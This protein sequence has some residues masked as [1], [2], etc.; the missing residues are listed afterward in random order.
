MSEFTVD[1]HTEIPR[2]QFKVLHET[3]RK[4]KTTVGALVAELVRRGLTEPTAPA[5]KRPGR[6]GPTKAQ[7]TTVRE[8]HALNRSDR[9]IAEAMGIGESTAR[10]W[11]GQL[12]LPRVRR[13]L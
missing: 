10:R 1:V 3:A 8:M 7:L 9:D 2:G 11:R 12:K 13:S 5:L 6:P 4:H